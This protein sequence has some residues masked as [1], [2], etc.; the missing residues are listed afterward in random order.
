MQLPIYLFK[1]NT[2][3]IIIRTLYK[4]LFFL[5]LLSAAPAFAQKV[6]YVN[7]NATGA[8]DGSS[9]TNAFT[10]LKTIEI[11]AKIGDQIWVAKGIYSPGAT[12]VSSF[13]LQDGVKIYGGFAGI[14][15]SLSQRD[16][17]KIRTV[18]ETILH[19]K[20]EVSD[21]ASYH[22]VSNTADLTNATLLDGFTI[23][24]GAAA[25]A[26]N[27][28]PGA[29]YFG[30]GIYNT[31]GS[32]VFNNLWIKGNSAVYGGGMYNTGSPLLSNVL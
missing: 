13:I 29:N 9:W 30:G 2:P 27:S 11:R 32:P 7:I 14:E 6:W 12:A 17:S 8:N 15:T 4:L 19:G 31:S 16:L 25:S 10:D 26:T 1:K 18:N 20:K 24:G 22:V 23:T 28:N 5:L 3:S 21:I